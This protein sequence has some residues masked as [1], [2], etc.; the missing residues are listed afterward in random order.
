M[1]IDKAVI[2]A[3]KEQV[4]LIKATGPSVANMTAGSAWTFFD[5]VKVLITAHDELAVENKELAKLGP[6]YGEIA[7]SNSKL[8]AENE[9]LRE[10]IKKV[11]LN[12]DEYFYS[13]AG[14]VLDRTIAYLKAALKEG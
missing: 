13:N 3:I 5:W 7:E 2:K 1:D 4:D 11:V 14:T 6:F 12:A 8:K 10:A 9:R